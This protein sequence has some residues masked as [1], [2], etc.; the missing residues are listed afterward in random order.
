MKSDAMGAGTPVSKKDHKELLHE[1]RETLA[2][3]V[4][5]YSSKTFSHLDL[6]NVQK[7]QRTG[8]SMRRWLN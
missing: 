6:W 5:N 3:D 7:R 8:T 2:V 1:T 4:K